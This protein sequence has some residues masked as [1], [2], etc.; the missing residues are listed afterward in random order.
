MQRGKVLSEGPT[1]ARKRGF[2]YFVPSTQCQPCVHFILHPDG[3]HEEERVSPP[4]PNSS[5][6][7]HAWLLRVSS[8]GC[9]TWSVTTWRGPLLQRAQQSLLKVRPPAMCAAAH[10]CAWH[11]ALNPCYSL[12]LIPPLLEAEKGLRFAPS[13]SEGFSGGEC[14]PQ[15]RITMDSNSA[16]V[17]Q[18]AQV[19]SSCLLSACMCRHHAKWTPVLNP[20]QTPMWM[21]KLKMSNGHGHRT[22]TLQSQDAITSLSDAKAHLPIY[23]LIL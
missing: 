8:R 20:Q 22:S 5:E 13:Q 11:A 15:P 23:H 4:T 19:Q 18:A 14:G 7:V 12:L 16:S 1:P 9:F 17:T 21:E 10:H 3:V 2:Y 6:P